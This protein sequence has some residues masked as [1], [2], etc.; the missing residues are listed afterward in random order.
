MLRKQN[1]FSLDLESLNKIN[2]NVGASLSEMKDEEIKALSLKLFRF[3]AQQC[4]PMRAEHHRTAALIKLDGGIIQYLTDIN[5]IT[6]RD[7]IILERIK[8]AHGGELPKHTPT[9]LPSPKNSYPRFLATLR[10][11]LS[12]PTPKISLES[13]PAVTLSRSSST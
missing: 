9:P 1:V 8:I 7:A 10:P 3:N 5:N 4:G 13:G 2:A 11:A 6:L 12:E